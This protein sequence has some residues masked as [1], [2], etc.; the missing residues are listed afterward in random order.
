M[1][2]NHQPDFQVLHYDG[3]LAALFQVLDEL[4]SAAS[5]GNLR[6]ATPLTDRELVGWLQDCIYTAQETIHEIEQGRAKQQT[7]LRL[8]K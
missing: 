3:R 8:V 1:E 6:G 7:H 4:H 5:D 2:H